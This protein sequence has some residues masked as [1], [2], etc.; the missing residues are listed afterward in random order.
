MYKTS[1]KSGA[2]RRSIVEDV[3]S[4]PIRSVII[5]ACTCHA[6]LE[7]DLKVRPT[8]RISEADLKVRPTF[9]SP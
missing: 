8:V 6:S 7:A 1:R 5:A 4:R 3:T 9:E 2:C